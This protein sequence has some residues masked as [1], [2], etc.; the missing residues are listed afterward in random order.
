[1]AALSSVA[2]NYSIAANW[3][4]AYAYYY[5]DDSSGAPY[6]RANKRAAN[7]GTMAADGKTAKLNFKVLAAISEGQAASIAGD[8]TSALA[9]WTK[10]RG[11][12]LGIYYQAALRY[13]YKLDVDISGSAATAEHQGEGG[14]FWRV[15]A[16]LMHAHDEHL[17]KY[18]NDFY[19]M[20]N[21]PTGT[22]NKYCPLYYLLSQN[23]VGGFTMADA[24]MLTAAS[25][26]TCMGGIQMPS[27]I[28]AE[29]ATALD[30]SV[31]VKVVTGADNTTAKKAAYVGGPMQTLAKKDFSCPDTTCY[32]SKAVSYFTTTTWL[33]DYMLSALDATGQFEGT[34]DAARGEM[35]E[36]RAEA[37][38]KGLQDQIMFN[39][40]MG[41]L[42]GDVE[43]SSSWY[44]FY[45]YWAG[46]D[47]GG[48]PWARANKRCKNYKTCG[49]T[50]GDKAQVNSQIL[51]ATLSALANPAANGA[52]AKQTAMNN[53]ILV[54]Y[55]AALRYAY[56]MDKD[57]TA[58]T[59]TADHQGEGGAFWRV[60][61]PLMHELD[62]LTTAFVN[63]FYDMRNA[64]TGT[65]HYCPLATMLLANLPGAGNENTTD[66]TV[67]MGTL[68]GSTVT[69]PTCVAPITTNTKDARKT[70][71]V[72]SAPGAV[73]DY[74]P[75][76]IGAKA[77][78]ELAVSP[79]SVS[80]TVVAAAAAESSRRRLQS[81]T[82]EITIAV[83]YANA[84]EAAAMETAMTNLAGTA[85]KA[86][87]FLTA[88]LGREVTVTADPAPPAS[89]A[90]VAPPPPP[91]A[92]TGGLSTGGLVGII[93]GAIAGVAI[94]GGL[95]AFLMMKK[96]SGT[97]VVSAP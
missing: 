11:S 84:T 71:L 18:V 92:S 68:Q 75:G 33:D 43:S 91:P 37:I 26:V 20:T 62:P 21:A 13:A 34:L 42:N 69:L 57:I 73:A 74:P 7:Y 19:T 45:A 81:G 28:S 52:A 59:A 10:F 32:Y 82:V 6:A 94:I 47:P 25:A 60:I 50:E 87:S 31:Q 38:K 54:Y 30:A 78:K 29:M 51:L 35:S 1:M 58:E 44:M 93:I 5:G 41:A 77:A 48:A 40:A 89:G 27:T 8:S 17:T 46:N 65:G 95:V 56:L 85:A 39:A 67:V 22:D 24:G 88:A 12:V 61:A 36:A 97:K 15:V 86:S 4:L 16:P 63:N 3:D 83:Y 14:A 9:A 79:Q 66:T 64:P 76:K 49:G 70:T 2:A 80:V 72:L 23:L 90:A 53:A 96:K 55:Q